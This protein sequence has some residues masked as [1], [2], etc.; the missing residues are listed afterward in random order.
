MIEFQ[1]RGLPHAHILL[2]LDEASK[3]RIADDIDRVVSAEIPNV[4][5]CPLAFETV[6]K[7][8][9]HGPCGAHN[10][11]SPCMATRDG[12]G[13]KYCTKNF[14]RQ[15]I[16]ETQLN[17]QGYPK[18]RRRDGPT[19]A[20][21]DG[22]RIDSGWIVPHN[23]WLT[24]KYNAHI[25][26]EV[27]ASVAAVKYL[28]KYIYKGH[29]K[30][31]MAV[32]PAVARHRAEP[33]P[34]D[35]NEVH[36]FQDSRYISSCEALWRIFKFPLHAR[37][38]AV[39]RLPVH[40]EDHQQIRY[41][42]NDALDVAVEQ[43][44]D[45]QLMAW[46]K[47]NAIDP[48]AREH[49]YPDIPLHYTWRGHRW[50]RRKRAS[51]V[52]TRMFFVHPRDRERFCLRLLLRVVKGATSYAN[53]RTAPFPPQDGD[54]PVVFD[55]FREAAL[56]RELLEDDQEW[57]LLLQEAIEY[58]MPSR[59]RHLF[60]WIVCYCNPSNP[61]QL[62]I[63]FAPHLYD[64]FLY[65]LRTDAGLEV[66]TE[67]MAVH[68]KNSALSDINLILREMGSSLADIDNLIDQYTGDDIDHHLDQEPHQE[69]GPI[70]NYDRLN[71]EQRAAFVRIRDTILDGPAAQV[72]LF[73]IDGPGGTGK[74]FLYNTLIAYILE[75]GMEVIPVASSG[76]ASMILHGGR[77]AHSTFKIPLKIDANSTCFIPAE[78]ALALRIK[79]AN[80]IIWDEAPMM[81]RLIFEAVDRT[82]QDIMKD[83]SPFG[84][85]IMIFGG[86]FRQVTPVVPRGSQTQIENSSLKFS[87]FW[88]QVETLKLTRNM[89]VAD[90]PENDEFVRFL[91]RV[92]EGREPTISVNGHDNLINI[93]NQ[94]VFRPVPVDSPEGEKQFIRLI[95][96]DIEY[97]A[98]DPDLMAERA[99]LTCLNAK[100]DALNAS[101]LDLMPGESQ[102]Y[103]SMDSIPDEESVDAGQYST[104]FLNTLLPTGLP[105]H[106]LELKVGQPIILLRNMNP[107][108]GLC[109]GTRLII[110]QLGRRLIQ[111]EIMVGV[112]TGYRVFIS[113]IPL[114]NSDDDVAFP[115]KFRRTHFP[116]K[117]AFAMTI[118]KAQG[119]TLQRVGLYLPQ[120]VFGHGQLYVAL[121]RCARPNNL[122]VLIDNGYIEGRQGVYTRNVVFKRLLEE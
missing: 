68:A 27:C 2:I 21:G 62:W 80:V 46:F 64:D 113:R 57:T 106:T 98:L 63:Q 86:D 50:N 20:L 6:S 115:I 90:D 72:K 59:I 36:N 65:R 105:P 87:N 44:K 79:N 24:T 10:P 100:V 18:Y 104:E 31:R 78:S 101:A 107:S 38:P 49:T 11:N 22:T 7:S 114:T 30:T 76:I 33:N 14:P 95:Y 3:I 93:P 91:L 92:G 82:F 43:A 5:T 15:L 77:T 41:H 67:E 74:S 102:T 55:T 71:E 120:P 89:R 96:P 58:Q 35:I 25:N 61:L 111:A 103:T 19:I 60:A 85:K 9:V 69:P 40:L 117:P 29:D 8:M 52:I 116:I 94:H 16:A 34:N 17:E 23:L 81:S 26:V 97:Q 84:G 66:P 99:L 70:N 51:K 122:K 75:Q 45:T 73:F 119:Q 37:S 12:T 13:E 112:N 121:S 53:L 83:P 118:N 88:P 32:H 42:E 47:L 54:V 109:N 110:R 28:F 48:E 1:K 56:A 39:I 4:V 108:R